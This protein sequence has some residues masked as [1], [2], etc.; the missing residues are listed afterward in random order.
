MKKLCIIITAV[1]IIALAS[2]GYY[3]WWQSR[4][5]TPTLTKFS[6]PA[7]PLWAKSFGGNADDDGFDIAAD[8]SGNIVVIGVFTSPTITFDATTL[9]NAD[10]QGG[11]SDTFI[12]KYDAS[13]HVLWAKAIGGTSEDHGFR[14]AMDAF[15]NVLI[16]GVFLSPT[17]TFGSIVLTNAGGTCTT[18]G[19]NECPDMFVAKLDSNGNWLWARSAGGA[20]DD[21]AWGI[22]TDSTGNVL[23]TG[24]FASPT[25]AFGATVL[26]NADSTGTPSDY[27]IVK[28]DSTGN[29]L[30]AQGAGGAPYDYG[31]DVTVDASDNI[32][33]A[34][35]FDS[36]TI[37]FGSTVL[38]NGTDPSWPYDE[39]FVVKYDQGG[40]VLWARSA[41]GRYEDDGFTITT[42][43]SGNVL[44]T[45]YFTSPSLTFKAITL[46]NAGGTCSSG[47]AD[48]F[49]AK[50]DA[51]GNVLWAK[52]A[53]GANGDYG[54]AVSFDA[55]G[56]ALVI[57]YFES[58][59]IAFG[60]TILNNSDST[61]K[62]GDIF[63]VKYDV[64]GNVLWA[65]ATG[66]SGNEIGWSIT[67]ST[68]DESMMVTG[69]FASPTI[70]LGAA[71]LT[72]TGP[73]GT[74]DI[75]VARIK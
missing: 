27:F 47:C 75:F 39:L 22:A 30:W 13:G 48:F 42:D 37:N 25:I 45:G 28:Y 21:E 34:G 55:S 38:T 44:V 74:S 52:T 69:E 31:L 70:T 59:T 51:S 57:G 65:K 17:L 7:L 10:S 18:W 5:S 1:I 15:G 23:V 26:T 73:N 67:A 62:T 60:A 11:S 40:N 66:G 68:T 43:A 56:N 9:T 29:V 16:T 24:G 20:Y 41:A 33:I 32:L 49:I 58:P 3:W 63:F 64:N 53:G 50:Y 35:W 71:T 8:A 4:A 72:N 61:G 6:A 2:G 19:T 36:P 46:A 12:V 54:R 14:I